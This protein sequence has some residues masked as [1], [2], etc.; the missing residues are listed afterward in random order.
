MQARPNPRQFYNRS[1]QTTAMEWLNK[2]PN[3]RRTAQNRLQPPFYHM[4]IFGMTFENHNLRYKNLSKHSNFS[5]LLIL[6]VFRS[7][8]FYH[9]KE[10]NE[11]NIKCFYFIVF[12]VAFAS[13]LPL[14]N[15]KSRTKMLSQ[16]V[17]IAKPISTCRLRPC[18]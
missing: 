15:V 6:L 12:V 5:F 17:L 8:F 4:V 1:K 3:W 2:Q 11:G 10:R 16:L 7:V 18:I 13:P 9:E 14:K